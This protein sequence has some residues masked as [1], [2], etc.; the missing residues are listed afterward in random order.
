MHIPFQNY[1]A[2]KP[3][4]GLHDLYKGEYTLDKSQIE[5]IESLTIGDIY[6]DLSDSIKVILIQQIDG[7]FRKTDKEKAKIINPEVEVKVT[8]KVNTIM[9]PC[10]EEFAQS[11][12]RQLLL[13]FLEKWSQE[14]DEQQGLYKLMKFQ[15]T[16]GESPSFVIDS[17]NISFGGLSLMKLNHKK[18]NK[19]GRPKIIPAH[20]IENRF[21]S[22]C[23][24][25]FYIDIG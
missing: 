4:K 12:D 22:N 24:P 15:Y 11:C 16:Q 5:V 19:Y 23:T 17:Q 20:K 2:Y 10:T 25:D 3:F 7:V 1:I 9:F 18:A 6:T 14:Y 13:K 8:P 21:E